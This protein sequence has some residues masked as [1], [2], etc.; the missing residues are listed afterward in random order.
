MSG[1]CL[2]ILEDKRCIFHIQCKYTPTLY[3]IFRLDNTIKNGKVFFLQKQ[4][5]NPT[6]FP[7]RYPGTSIAVVTYSVCVC[8]AFISALH[9]AIHLQNIT[10]RDVLDNHILFVFQGFK[11]EL[12]QF[13]KNK[14][15]FAP[16]SLLAARPWVPTQPPGNLSINT[17]AFLAIKNNIFSFT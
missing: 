15:R 6:F 4:L 16:P 1:P 2:Q 8:S 7:T 17:W 10:A 3:G 9:P 13:S 14:N 11:L 12:N 5:K